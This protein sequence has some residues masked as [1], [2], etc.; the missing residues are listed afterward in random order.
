[1]SNVLEWWNVR[2]LDW[3]GEVELSQ[4]GGWILPSALTPHWYRGPLA[5]PGHVCNLALATQCVSSQQHEPLYFL[6]SLP[7]FS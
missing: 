6:V 3:K 2:H 7:S 1:M 4:D 5:L